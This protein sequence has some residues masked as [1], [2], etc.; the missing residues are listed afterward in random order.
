MVSLLRRRRFIVL[1]I[2]FALVFYF[3]YVGLGWNIWVS[4][5]NWIGLRIGVSAMPEFWQLCGSCFRI[6]F[7]WLSF[8]NTLLFVSQLSPSS[9]VIGGCS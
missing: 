6:R 9:I 2:P 4:L 5:T 8:R 7:F 1:V 3:V